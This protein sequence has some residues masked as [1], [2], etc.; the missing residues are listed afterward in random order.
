MHLIQLYLEAYS[1]REKKKQMYLPETARDMVNNI[2][3]SS[4]AAVVNSLSEIQ[5]SPNLPLPSSLFS[6]NLF[7]LCVRYLL[8]TFQ[9]E[10]EREREDGIAC[11][12]KQM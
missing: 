10:R 2:I 3:L 11:G 7:Y 9:R 6:S 4:S 1:H 8:H 5:A 12:V